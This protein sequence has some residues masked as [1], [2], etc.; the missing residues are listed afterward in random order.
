MLGQSPPQYCCYN[1][2]GS[3]VRWRWY[4][5]G[6]PP[7][8]L[9]HWALILGPCQDRVTKNVEKLAPELQAARGIRKLLHPNLPDHLWGWKQGHS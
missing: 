7:A 8:H 6:L 5:A 2:L 1:L 4:P 3:Q 9:A